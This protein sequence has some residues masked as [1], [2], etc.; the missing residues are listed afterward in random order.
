[1]SLGIVQ[2]AKSQDSRIENITINTDVFPEV[3]FVWK[4]DCPIVYSSNQ[5][6]L[7]ENEKRVDSFS[8]VVAENIEIDSLM[9]S[10][11]KSVLIL[12]EDQGFRTKQSDFA[13]NTIYYFFEE[14]KQRQG[15]SEFYYDTNDRFSLCVFNKLKKGEDLLLTLSDFT[16]D[17]SY[18]EDTLSKYDAS[19]HG[20]DRGYWQK[21]STD[22]FTAIDRGIAK[23]E[24]EP[25]ENIK[26]LFVITAGITNSLETN[27][28]INRSLKNKIPVYVID[29]N[30]AQINPSIIQVVENTYGGFIDVTGNLDDK[31]IRRNAI[32]D[33][34]NAYNTMQKD[35]FGQ[36]YLVS[37]VSNELRNGGQST[38]LFKVNG[39][40]YYITYIRPS[41]SLIL[42]AKSHLVLF[43]I[44]VVVTI[45][46]LGVGVFF[47]VRYIKRA[48]IKRK[49]QKENKSK[50][51]AN[52]LAEQEMLKRQIHVAEEELLK[53]KSNLEKEKQNKAE[54][55]R[56]E[57]L[58]DLMQKK[59]LFPRLMIIC[60]TNQVF[61]MHNPTVFIG[62]DE[63][64]DIV[65]PYQTIS[66]R[67][68]KIA[69]DGT[70]FEIHDLGSTN[71]VIVNDLYINSTIQLRNGDIINIGDVIIKF[72]I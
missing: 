29:Y 9:R 48:N 68:A 20:T 17:I 49:K 45:G 32:G 28:I 57:E 3:S 38:I 21:K 24:M 64:N 46:A 52:M 13:N 59:G 70:G 66:R 22:L 10:R 15:Q 34:L 58:A 6:A 51:E 63:D 67:H 2:F 19:V 4:E 43:I 30:S 37:F 72:Y 36:D 55:E 33:M 47:L 56:E 5:F 16:V 18:I 31:E 60:E 40:S 50:K 44:L 61:N 23:L 35:Y 39:K 69:F 1:M 7:F 54:Q 11:N 12:W 25:E 65:L 8:I 62:R 71:G 26:A 41:F 14:L 42:W 53:H 27:Q